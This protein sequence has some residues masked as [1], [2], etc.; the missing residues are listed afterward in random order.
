MI[1]LTFML[2]ISLPK[3]DRI[4]I[5]NFP[6]KI[7]IVSFM[8]Y[9]NLLKAQGVEETIRELVEDPFFDLKNLIFWRMRIGIKLVRL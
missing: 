7:G 9:P 5:I 6:W 4:E 2:C 1:I 8:A 3:D